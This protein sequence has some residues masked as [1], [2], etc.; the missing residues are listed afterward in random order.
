MASSHDIDRIEVPRIP[1]L[2]PLTEE[3]Q[4]RM[5]EALDELRRRRKE[6]LAA[7]GG[8]PFPNSWEEFPDL[9]EEMDPTYPRSEVDEETDA[10]EHE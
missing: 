3:E 7:H 6:I 8:V 9:Y 4:R 10:E 2:P 5:A 1:P